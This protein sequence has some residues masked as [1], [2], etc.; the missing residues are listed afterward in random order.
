[1]Q[2]MI[3]EYVFGPYKN[4]AVIARYASR[5]WSQQCWT[6]KAGRLIDKF[7][8]LC[9]FRKQNTTQVLNEL[10]LT[11]L[12]ILLFLLKSSSC[13]LLMLRMTLQFYEFR[14]LWNHSRVLSL[15]LTQNLPT[16]VQRLLETWNIRI[17]LKFWI[18]LWFLSLLLHHWDIST[19]LLVRAGVTASFWD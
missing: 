14:H 9:L 2:S 13:E 19:L 7:W 5:N 8:F 17:E 16:V 4:R 18:R 12:S 6:W 3:V 10:N 11:S 15:S 1:M